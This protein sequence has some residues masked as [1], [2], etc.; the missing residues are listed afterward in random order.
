LDSGDR[1]TPAEAPLYGFTSPLLIDSRFRSSIPSSD[2]NRYERGA[3]IS[4]CYRVAETGLIRRDGDVRLIADTNGRARVR[5]SS[6]LLNRVGWHCYYAT[7]DQTIVAHAP[8]LDHRRGVNATGVE[9][10]YI[11][12]VRE[13]GE[14][15]LA[16]REPDVGPEKNLPLVCWYQ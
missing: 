1:G 16:L 10:S 2:A 13:H 15:T 5:E 11:D 7:L 8:H 12:P 14:S 4:Q 3:V 9:N 6:E